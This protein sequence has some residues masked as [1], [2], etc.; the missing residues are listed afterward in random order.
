[1]SYLLNTHIAHPATSTPPRNIAKQYAPYRTIS[2]GLSR[3][4]IP[5]TIEAKNEKTNAALK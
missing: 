2:R 1:M 5:N 3:W 4:V